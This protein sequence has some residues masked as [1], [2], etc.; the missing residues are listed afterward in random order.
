[1]TVEPWLAE[2]ERM[3]RQLEVKKGLRREQQWVM[4][5]SA[6]WAGIKRI[7]RCEFGSVD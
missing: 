4:T 6:A 1:M 7:C 5:V 2:M 3:M